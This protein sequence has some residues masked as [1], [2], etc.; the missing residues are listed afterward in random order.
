ML[1]KDSHFCV[2]N[3]EL[4]V[5]NYIFGE[6]HCPYSENHKLSTYVTIRVKTQ[7][8]P[9]TDNYVKMCIRTERTIL[10]IHQQHKT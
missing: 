1:I 9:M 8:T 7:D 10:T 6:N 2:N 3:R 4:K 5:Y